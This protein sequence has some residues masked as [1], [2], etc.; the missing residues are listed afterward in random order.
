MADDLT[1]QTGHRKWF[2][3][4]RRIEDIM[5]EKGIPPNVDFYSAS[6]YGSLGLDPGIFTPIFA[7]SRTSGWL[8]HVLE[9][10]ADN[11]LIRPRANY[12]GE[13]DGRAFTPLAE[14]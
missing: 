13:A 8:A 6:V 1:T 10:H 2:E 9:Q 14:R 3:M 4:S 7:V 11:R 5:K 12:I